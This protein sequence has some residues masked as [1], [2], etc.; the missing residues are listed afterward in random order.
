MAK[1]IHSTI[2]KIAI[3]EYMHCHPCGC[4]W[5]IEQGD[6]FYVRDYF[7]QATV[8]IDMS[9]PRCGVKGSKILLNPYVIHPQR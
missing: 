4:V 3:G 7:E 2:D 8:I 1:I 6:P 9:C 5:E